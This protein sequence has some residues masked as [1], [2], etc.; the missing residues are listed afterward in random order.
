MSVLIPAEQ[1]NHMLTENSKIFKLSIMKNYYIIVLMLLFSA[2]YFTNSKNNSVNTIEAFV[3]LPINGCL[4][5]VL[6][7]SDN[8]KDNP[9]LLYLHG[10]PGSS[11]MMY[12]YLYE[13]Q[14]K[15]NFIYVNWDM[16]GA[17][18]S[19]HENI[20]PRSV[21]QGQIV[22]DSI[23]LI[24]YLLKRFH[25]NKIFLIG[26]SFGSALGLY[27]INNYPEFFH[28]YIGIGQV[29]SY[30]K[31]VEE[32]YK[33]LHQKL[34]A[35]NDLKGLEQIKKEH[36]PLMSLIYK[37]GG[38][39]NLNINLFNLIKK[40]PYYFEGYLELLQKGKRFSAENVGKNPSRFGSEFEYIKQVSVP[41]YFFEG[42]HDHVVAC[43]PKLVEEFVRKVKAPKKEI[44]WFLNSAHYVPVEEP[45]KFQNE[46]VRVLKA[47][48]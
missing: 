19:Y 34:I 24:N 1:L 20:D 5:K 47:T 28:A 45:E 44:V 4:Q 8:I 41:L 6:I 26:H 14:L 42:K 15:K 18:L 30:K 32:T 17:A 9:I 38:H 46:M 3:D 25:K 10:G 16:R 40:S 33:W 37:Y 27:L 11:L 22:D 12:S 23:A 43:S 13:H 35:E 7:Q 21:S 36:F 31:S 39:H 2:S 48:L 29:I